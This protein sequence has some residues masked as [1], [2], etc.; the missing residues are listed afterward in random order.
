MSKNQQCPVL[1]LNSGR[2][3]RF[4]GKKELQ[5]YFYP[6]CPETNR[7]VDELFTQIAGGTNVKSGTIDIVQGRQMHI[8]KYLK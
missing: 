3:Y 4:G 7:E 5:T 1:H 6:P 8:N 2:D